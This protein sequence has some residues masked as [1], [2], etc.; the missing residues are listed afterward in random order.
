MSK[1]QPIIQAFEAARDRY[2]EFGVDVNAEMRSLRTI[3]ISMHRWQGDDIGGY[4]APDASPT[5]D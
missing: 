5:G 1:D 2:A 4:E 3:P